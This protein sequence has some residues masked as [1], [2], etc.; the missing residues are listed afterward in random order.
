MIAARYQIPDLS[1]VNSFDDLDA[2]KKENRRVCCK[3]TLVAVRLQR[4]GFD[5][6]NTSRGVETN[7]PKLRLFRNR[8]PLTPLCRCGS[9]PLPRTLG[10]PSVM[11]D[12]DDAFVAL[13]LLKANSILPTQ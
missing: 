8:I 12:N 13:G 5:T 10:T 7:F 1:V 4:R 6:F 9:V 3:Y 2:A 11:T